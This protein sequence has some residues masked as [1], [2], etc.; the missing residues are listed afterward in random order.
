[1]MNVFKFSKASLA[2]LQG[3]HGDLIF[4]AQRALLLTPIDF[5]VTEGVR[6]QERQRQLYEQHKTPT[7]NSRHLTGHA[8][9]V[10]A[11]HG[12]TCSWY[13]PDYELIAVAFKQAA[14]ELGLEVEWGGDWKSQDGVHFQLSWKSYP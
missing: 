6:T 4:I 1:M 14:H 3:V 11:W 7:L 2:K 9:D 10:L 8:I 5:S 13:F 12:S